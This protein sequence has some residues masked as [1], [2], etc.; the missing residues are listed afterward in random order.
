MIIKFRKI[1]FVHYLLLLLPWFLV[2]SKFCAEISIAILGIY[3]LYNVFKNK[4]FEYFNNLYS[5]FFFIFYV[6]IVTNAIFLTNSNLE[7]FKSIAYIRFYLF[8]MSV[9]LILKNDK[10]IYKYF[11]YSIS[12]LLFLIFIG[13]FYELIYKKNIL[14]SIVIDPLRIS[15]FFGDELIMGSFVMRVFPLYLSL[16]FFLFYKKKNYFFLILFLFPILITLSGERSSLMLF[17]LSLIYLGLLLELKI[18][19]IASFFGIIII[20]IALLISFNSNLNQRLISNTINDLTKKESVFSKINTSKIYIFSIYHTNYY[21]TSLK[22]VKDNVFFGQG[23][24]SYRLKCSHKKFMVDT[25]SCSTHPHNTYMQL[26][27]ETGLIGFLI[28]FS[29]FVYFMFISIRLFFYKYF[30]GYKIDNLKICFFCCFIITLW[31]I[32]PT[33]NFFSSW[34]SLMYYLPIGFYFGLKNRNLK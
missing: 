6:Y 8:S 26:L 34:M 17:F 32:A 5:Y 13:A 31:P 3:F 18:K 1:I 24:K 11:F 10:E 27:A 15:S 21:I 20:L 9:F 30:Y 7:I 16:Y 23:F 33:G 12:L 4:K 25:D 14:L 2:F 29:I 22:M 19:K 28:I